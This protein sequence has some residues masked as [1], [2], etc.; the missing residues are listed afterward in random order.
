MSVYVYLCFST[1]MTPRAGMR[2][3][4]RPHKPKAQRQTFHKGL[5]V[6]NMPLPTCVVCQVLRSGDMTAF[7]GPHD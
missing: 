2:S 6:V 7:H 4:K 3:G 1:N 5:S